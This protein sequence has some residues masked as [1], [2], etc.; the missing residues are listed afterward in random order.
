MPILLQLQKLP[1]KGDGGWKKVSLRRFGA[2]RRSRVR[3][4]KKSFWGILK[5]EQQVIAYFQTHYS[6]IHCQRLPLWRKYAPEV[7]AAKGFKRC[8][9]MSRELTT[10]PESP[11]NYGTRVGSMDLLANGIIKA[12]RL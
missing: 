7:K 11:S 4:E 6:Q 8:R 9:Q 5:H 1:W 12:I 3:R 2:D 10:P